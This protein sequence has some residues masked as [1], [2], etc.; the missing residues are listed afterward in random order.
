[1]HF[2]VRMEL[3]YISNDFSF[4]FSAF[5]SGTRHDGRYKPRMQ[6]RRNVNDML[7]D[8]KYEGRMDSKRGSTDKLL[9]TGA[10]YSFVRTRL[11]GKGLL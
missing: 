7:F 6:N 1:M 11:Q 10:G 3:K 4:R 5:L 9:Q 2:S 8:I